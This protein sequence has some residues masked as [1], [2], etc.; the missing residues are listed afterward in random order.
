MWWAGGGDGGVEALGMGGMGGG[1][2]RWQVRGGRASG[3]E[4]CEAVGWE[5]RV[6]G[7]EGQ[8]AGAGRRSECCGP[9]ARRTVGSCGVEERVPRGGCG[10]EAEGRSAAD[11]G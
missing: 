4:G 3:G 8:A 10:C 5:V 11:L 9:G 7:E 1:R 6:R 2:A